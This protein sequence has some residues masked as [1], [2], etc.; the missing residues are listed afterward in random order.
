MTIERRL[1]DAIADLEERLCEGQAVANA[2][3]ETAE[4]YDLKSHILGLRASNVL[5]DLS[6]VKDKS[7]ARIAAARRA[8]AL[9]DAID[10]YTDEDAD[11]SMRDWLISRLGRAPSY[12]E[13][14]AA[15]ERSTERWFAKQVR[16]GKI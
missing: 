9:R 14:L 13:L 11:C 15:Y 2:L 7:D 16:E 3:A 6:L 12:E 8:G 1:A 5:G 4:E 10:A